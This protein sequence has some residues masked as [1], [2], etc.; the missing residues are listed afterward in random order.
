MQIK[1]PNRFSI[2]EV[3]NRSEE[4]QI[5][6]TR[7]LILAMTVNESKDRQETR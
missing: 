2:A 7:C 5:N 1:R 4:E 6:T 3:I